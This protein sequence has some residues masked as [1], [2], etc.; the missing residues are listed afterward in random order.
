MQLRKIVDVFIV[1]VF[2]AFSTWLMTKSFG[3]DVQKHEFRIS[4]HQVGDFGLHIA[5]IRSFSWGNNFPPESPFYP[6]K[7]LPYHYAFDFVVGL[8]ER[9]GVRIDHAL[10]GIS[11]VFFTLLLYLIYRFSQLLFGKGTLLGLFSVGLF[12]FP[13]T[14]SFLDF[15]KGKTLRSQ[16]FTDIWQLPDYIHKGPFDGSI[17]SLFFTLNPFLNQRHFIVGMAISLSILMVVVS[18]ILKGQQLSSKFLFV[19]GIVVGLSIRVHSL[20]AFGTAVV[21]IVLLMLFNRIKQVFPFALSALI[22]ALPHI[23]DILLVA[24]VKHPFFNPGYLVPRPLTLFGFFQFWWLNLGLALVLIPAGYYFASQKQRNVFLSFF[25]LFLIANIF[26]LSFRI[27]H[28]HSLITLFLV[29]ANAFS[30]FALARLWKKSVHGKGTVLIASFVLFA[31][32]VLNLMV[33]KNDFHYPV[34]DAPNNRLIEW[35]KTTTPTDSIFLARQDLY[36]P[37]TLAG[38]KNYFGATYY[39]E[40]MGYDITTRRAFVKEFFEARSATALSAMRREGIDYMIIPNGTVDNFSYTVD[41]L[42]LQTNLELVYNDSEV[43]VLKL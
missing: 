5:L 18:K 6:G 28:N 9:S 26:Q 16:L 13:S 7:P 4:R 36:D 12:L 27:E 29:V 25:L 37:V 39:L 19:L 33:V 38:R 3:Y 11:I 32:G 42:F 24:S 21:V 31:S 2:L 1:V 40:V 30:A 23:R 35:I 34:L 15:I 41:Q 43:T 10:N 14:L 17:I 22:F 20:L 8:L